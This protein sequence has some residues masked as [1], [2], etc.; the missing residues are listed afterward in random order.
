[1]TSLHDMGHV[2]IGAE[3]AVG[4]KHGTG[5]N[6]QRVVIDNGTESTVLI[7]LR[8]GLDNSVRITIGIQVKE[9]SQVDT[10]GTFS[11]IAL[12][13][14]IGIG[15]ELGTAQEGKRRAIGGEEA[16]IGV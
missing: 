11:G 14:K 2:I 9:S 6:G 7:L 4:D 5:G 13:S 1:M 16:V 3:A 15:G 10:E 12:G 8:D